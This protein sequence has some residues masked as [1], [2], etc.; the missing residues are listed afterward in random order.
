[1]PKLAELI[2]KIKVYR[3]TFI[4]SIGK[5]TQQC[6]CKLLGKFQTTMIIVNILE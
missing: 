3:N 4:E 6:V 5:M 1:M 2:K